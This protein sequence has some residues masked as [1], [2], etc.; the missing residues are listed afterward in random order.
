MGVVALRTCLATI[1]RN[2][3]WGYMFVI[4]K[5]V[6]FKKVV[7]IRLSKNF[8]KFSTRFFRPKKVYKCLKCDIY[9]YKMLWTLYRLSSNSFTF[10]HNVRCTWAFLTFKLSINVH[11]K[12]IGD[13][14][15]FLRNC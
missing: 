13:Q 14:K 9:F 7:G 3:H 1:V 10:N 2:H 11:A 15:F 12:N 5:N 4:Y 6:V 8:K